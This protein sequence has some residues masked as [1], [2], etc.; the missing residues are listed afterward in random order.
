MFREIGGAVMK[1]EKAGPRTGFC[2]VII[3]G[4]ASLY[5]G[6]VEEEFQRATFL[7]HQP[8]RIF[9]TWRPAA[10][11]MAPRFI[12]TC[13]KK[14]CF[15]PARGVQTATFRRRVKLHDRRASAFLTNRICAGPDGG[16]GSL[17]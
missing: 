3:I 14:S 4:N 10:I 12:A 13:S 8:I 17:G 11:A 1:Q 5:F 2:M 6:T 7:L 16:S 15:I 9:V